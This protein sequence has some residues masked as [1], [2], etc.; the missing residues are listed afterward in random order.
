MIGCADSA[1][2]GQV[3]TVTPGANG[4]RVVLRV[5]HWVVP[6][7][8]ADTVEFLAD[9]PSSQVGVPA[10]TA[11]D[12]GLL[13]LNRSS[14]PSLFSEDAGKEV[15]TAWRDAGARRLAR[16]ALSRTPPPAPRPDTER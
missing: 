6:D 12:H 3:T 4:L 5:D 15:E 7:K 8:G 11:G 10:W 14:P 16:N 1:T 2:W 13:V 9:N